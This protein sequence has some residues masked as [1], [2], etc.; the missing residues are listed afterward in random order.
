[1][2]SMLPGPGDEETWPPY[3]GHPKDPRTPD[4][5]YEGWPFRDLPADVQALR[6]EQ[7]ERWQLL[8]IIEELLE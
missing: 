5:P 2:P 1:M 3:A 4:D 6:L 8:E 7:A